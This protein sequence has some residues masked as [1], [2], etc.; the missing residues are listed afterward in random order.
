MAAR[1]IGTGATRPLSSERAESVARV[2][3]ATLVSTGD[4]DVLWFDRASTPK[5]TTAPTSTV[6]TPA[7][8]GSLDR[9]GGTASVPE[10]I[11]AGACPTSVAGTPGEA[12]ILVRASVDT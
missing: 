3:V 10:V 5:T 2:D 8:T 7:I 1:D 4:A 11:S 12:R 9:R 6:A